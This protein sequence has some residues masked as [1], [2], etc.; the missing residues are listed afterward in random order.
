MKQGETM[1]ILTV[2]LGSREPNKE[3][4]SRSFV[5][6]NGLKPPTGFKSMKGQLI[7]FGLAV[8]AMSACLAMAQDKDKDHDR[9][10]MHHH[11]IVHQR[12]SPWRHGKTY[13]IH[14]KSGTQTVTLYKTRRTGKRRTSYTYVDH[15]RPFYHPKMRYSQ[16]TWAEKVKA[17][18][19]RRHH[20]TWADAVV[21]SGKKKHHS[22]VW[23]K[24]HRSR[25]HHVFTRDHDNGRHLGWYKG[26]GNPHRHGNMAP[27][28]HGKKKDHGDHDKDH[29]KGD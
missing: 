11:H 6:D 20:T 5:I 18:Q 23:W 29:G 27:F 4:F 2:F 15:S 25:T 8:F 9:D 12:V 17:S 3:P 16:S 7:R 19:R 26:R 21:R 14:R 1:A 28:G 10:K 24:T 13:T 22:T